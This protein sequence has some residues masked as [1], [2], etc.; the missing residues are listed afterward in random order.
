LPARTT[1]GGAIVAVVS[2]K[3]GVGKTTIALNLSLA[4]AGQHVS[5]VLLD[6]TV[7]GDLDSALAE[8]AG[9][10]CGLADLLVGKAA[11]DQ[12]LLPTVMPHLSLV[13]AGSAEN[14]DT[15][16]TYSD[17]RQWR[18]VLGEVA[19]RAAVVIVDTPA[20]IAGVT[21]NIIA[22]SSHVLGVL[23]AEC[24]AQRT[25]NLLTHAID[26]VGAAHRPA[27]LGVVVNM[28]QHEHSTSLGVLATV[29]TQLPRALPFTCTL[30]RAPAVLEASRAGVP[31]RLLDPARPPAVSWLF[32][33]LAAEV[34]DRLSLGPAREGKPLKLLP[35]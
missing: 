34:A 1:K 14:M 7:T 29:S 13:P 24:L 32:D 25:F 5:V 2:P 16:L 8:R 18:R 9:T 15:A 4:L 11:L 17:Q 6:G 21:Q 28:L 26:R 3:G 33:A 23:Q 22:S 19:E 35:S 12:V 10:R 30:P 20:G 31:V 27:V